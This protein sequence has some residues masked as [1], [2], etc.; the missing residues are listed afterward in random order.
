MKRNKQILI[1]AGIVIVIVIVAAVLVLPWLYSRNL[2]ETK[3][4]SIGFHMKNLTGSGPLGDTVY[5]DNESF[6][7]SVTVMPSDDCMLMALVDYQAVPFYF[8]GRLNSTHYL[9]G[10]RT[11]EYSGTVSITNLSDGFHDVVLIGFVAPYNFSYDYIGRPLNL[12]QTG[13][14]RLNVI[15]G[16]ATKPAAVFENSTTLAGNASYQPDYPHAG[17][18]ISWKPFDN[19]TLF[20]ENLRPGQVLDYYLQVGHGIIDG[21]KLDTSYAIVQLLDYHQ[22]PVR[23]NSSD[24][25]YYGFIAV[26]E[27]S[28]VH[29]SLK[30]PD[31][32]G[33]HRLVVMLAADPYVNLEKAPGVMNRNMTRSITAEYLDIF[34]KG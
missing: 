34:V 3:T 29:L 8:D 25:V 19:R 4:N 22:V 14:L 32:P 21:R 16:N 30:V 20:R 12:M 31:M 23:Y 27:S 15:A 13:S 10:S 11:G 26:N 24:S 7:F 18:H 1:A 6:S 28:S 33:P 9:S 5:T 2:P 17:P